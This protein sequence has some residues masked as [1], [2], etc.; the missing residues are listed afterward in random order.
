MRTQGV[1]AITTFGLGYMRPASGTWGSLPPIILAMILEA[2]GL[3]A[4]TAPWV[5]NG[6]LLGVAVFFGL[7]CLLQGDRAEAKWGKDPSN[8]VADETCGQCIPLL[9]LPVGA[10]LTPEANLFT[11]GFAFVAFRVL[12][13][14]K[15]WPARG[16]QRLPGGLG[17]LID[18]VVAGV[19]A[20]VLVQVCARAT[21]G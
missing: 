9:F 11:L 16:L 2:A 8:A 6:V 19:M 13:I 15:P 18:D 5:Y 14:V 3:G 12:D 21:V 17:I 20:M 1:W 4:I 10:T 7:A